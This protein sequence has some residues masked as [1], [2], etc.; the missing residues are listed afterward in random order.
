MK[1]QTQSSAAGQAMN[2]QETPEWH[3][4]PSSWSLVAVSWLLVGVPL[5]WGIYKTFEKAKVLLF[6]A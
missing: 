4:D 1:Q 2:A 3:A 6:G 5:L